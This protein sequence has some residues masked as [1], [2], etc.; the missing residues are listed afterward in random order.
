VEVRLKGGC[1]W[2]DFAKLRQ[3]GV[4]RRGGGSP[5]KGC[6]GCGAGMSHR[7]RAVWGW[8]V[9]MLWVKALAG[10]LTGGMITVS[11]D[12]IFPT[13]ASFWSYNPTAPDSLGEN[14]IR[15]PDER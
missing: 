13:G 11:L 7:A 12:V 8:G 1:V 9:G 2:S 6:C 14:P 15:I 4:W 5:H 10:V 3:R